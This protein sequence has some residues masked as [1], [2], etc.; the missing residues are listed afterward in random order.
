MKKKT[1][2]KKTDKESKQEA[3]VEEIEEAPVSSKEPGPIEKVKQSFKK[4]ATEGRRTLLKRLLQVKGVETHEIQKLYSKGLM[5][6][7]LLED[8]TLGDLVKASGIK[9]DFARIIKEVLVRKDSDVPYEYEKIEI[10]R[11]NQEINSIHSKTEEVRKETEHLDKKRTSIETEMDKVI[12]ERDQLLYEHNK[13][14]ETEKKCY[15]YEKRIQDEMMFIIKEE[16]A[17]KE[18]VDRFTH[19]YGYSEKELNT[20]KREFLFTKGECSYILEKINFLVDKLDKVIKVKGMSQ[21]KLTSFLNELR[22]VHDT[23]ED[24]YKK[25]SKKY[26]ADKQ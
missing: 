5:E 8:L 15:F 10:E 1:A 13:S 22:C 17:V 20:I 23:L 26:Y 11:L 3:I 18:D 16:G 2:G 12:E 14:R 25:T 4:G 7:D 6:P 19:N 24:A 9:M 21:D